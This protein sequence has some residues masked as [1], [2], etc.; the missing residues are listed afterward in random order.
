MQ[1]GLASTLKGSALSAARYHVTARGKLSCA[2]CTWLQSGRWLWHGE[3]GE[4]EGCG[5]GA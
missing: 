5:A 3:R 4:Q 2:S 1:A